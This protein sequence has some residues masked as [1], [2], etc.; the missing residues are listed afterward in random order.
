MSY[1]KKLFTAWENLLLFIPYYFSTPLLLRT[2]FH[3]WKREVWLK[4]RP[5][6]HLEEILGRLVSNLL[7]RLIGAF[8][9]SLM[10][11]AAVLAEILVF[12]FGLPLLLIFLPI[13]PAYRG[14]DRRSL[15]HLK[16]NWG[17]LDNLFK[18][19]PLA[20]DWHFGYTPNLDKYNKIPNLPTSGRWSFKHVFLV[21]R[22]KEIAQIKRIFARESQNNVLLVGEPG[23]GRHAIINYLANT[24]FYYRF[25]YFDLVSLF[26]DKK[27]SPEQRGALE[28]ILQE[29]KAA[30]NIVLIFGDF[31]KYVNFADVWEKFIA[32]S[33]L[34]VLALSTPAAYYQILFPNKTLMKYFTKVDVPSLTR[35]QVFE[36][37]KNRFAQLYPSP[38]WVKAGQEAKLP[39]FHLY[40]PDTR[41]QILEILE[42]ILEASYQTALLQDTHQPEAAL[43]LLEEFATTQ[44]ESSSTHDRYK[45]LTTQEALEEFLEEKLKV[46]VG[47]LKAEER[48]KLTHLEKLL[49]Q[50]VVNQ[51]EAITGIASALRRRRLHLAEETKPIGSFLFLGPTGV[52]KTETA[53]ALAA[54]FFENEKFLLRFDMARFQEKKQIVALLEELAATI[55]SQPYSVLLLDEIDKAQQDLLNLFLTILD[56]G[57]FLD[58]H[59]NRV[60][61][62][63]LIIIGTSNAASEFIREKLHTQA[64]RASQICNLGAEVI[65]FILKH[66]IFSP[67]FINRFDAVVVYQPLSPEHLKQIAQMKLEKLRQKLQKEHGKT[68]E[69]SEELLEQ[70]VKEDTHPEFGAREIERTI[71]RL[72]EDQLAAELLK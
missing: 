34:Y 57:Y 62:Q 41:N 49:H 35:K 39:R 19:K 8:L 36:V 60:P 17:H 47:K 28:E 40:Q 14:D 27:T 38:T 4:T 23:S 2:F 59:A 44:K 37:L 16:H 69:I 5:G 51:E 33:S 54:I 52:G 42:T 67:E 25:V 50:R 11:F 61:C 56:E 12:L 68:F 71:K 43:D 18:I 58:N 72:V 29:A 13:I 63:N 45:N 1:L 66:N 3:P 9:R 21:G 70:I 22:E 64:T 20:A 10:I 30:G 24:M 65:N 6:F 26:K 15:I 31:E 7:S 55:R 32:G 46:P 53:K 48:E